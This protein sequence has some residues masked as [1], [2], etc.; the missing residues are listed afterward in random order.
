ML[1]LLCPD[2]EAIVPKRHDIIAKLAVFATN[3]ELSNS[4]SYELRCKAKIG[5]LNILLGRLY[6]ES[7]P[8]TITAD[9]YADLRSLSRELA[10]SGLDKELQAF[11]DTESNM[12]MS[13]KIETLEERIDDLTR[14][15]KAIL[16][17][18]STHEAFISRFTSL[19]E[20][21][22]TL[23][24]EIHRSVTD[25]IELRESFTWQCRDMETQ[26]ANMEQVWER[27]LSKEVQKLK[28][29]SSDSDSS[30]TLEP[31]PDYLMRSQPSER[32]E[33][34]ASLSPPK[35]KKP[36]VKRRVSQGVSKVISYSEARPL[37]GII[38]Y[39][40]RMCKGN[41]HDNGIVTVTASSFVGSGYPKNV[42]DLDTDS[43]YASGNVKDTWICYDFG[44]REIIPKSYS[45]RSYEFGPG[46]NHLKSWVIEVSKTGTEGS[47]VE[48][49]RR[50]NNNDLNDCHVIG[51]FDIAHV[52][53]GMYRFFRL[54]QI[55]ENHDPG[56]Y[57]VKLTA[58]EVFGTLVEKQK[59]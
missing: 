32:K 39:L 55:G 49:D 24:K 23:Q 6:S 54:K 51:H 57:Y 48:I 16:R 34:D 2:G 53:A 28:P 38:E 20:K 8:V 21:L 18:L 12:P 5:S 22:Q 45:L 30:M 29:S 42:V 47:W 44:E 33:V 46:N 11:E 19:E 41:V 14:Q 17:L 4:S 9:N 1:R 56:Y 36:P 10:F 13:K 40:T 50:N 26:I 31:L 25:T 59:K 3:P 43:V 37:G 7:E 58:L 27:R 52:P 15:N 35:R